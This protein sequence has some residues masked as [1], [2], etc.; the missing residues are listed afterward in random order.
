MLTVFSSI[1]GKDFLQAALGGPLKDMY[2]LDQDFE[3]IF[4]WDI[5]SLF[6][7]Y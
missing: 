1:V 7:S 4:L 3:V 5:L 2:K 6:M